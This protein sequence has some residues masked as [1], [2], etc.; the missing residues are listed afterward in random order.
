[1]VCIT[2]EGTSAVMRLLSAGARMAAARIRM[3]LR[4]LVT[5]RFSLPPA[6]PRPTALRYSFKV[7]SPL[8]FHS[9]TCKQPRSALQMASSDATTNPEEAQHNALNRDA[10]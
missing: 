4:I 9:L 2:K 1:M 3:A 6:H 7:S 5:L 8:S 10:M